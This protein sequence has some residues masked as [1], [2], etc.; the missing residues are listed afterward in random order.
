M[1]R[2]WGLAPMFLPEFDTENAQK[3]APTRG[4]MALLMTHDITVWPLWCNVN[5]ANRAMIA[6]DQYDVVAS[7]FI[8]YFGAKPPATSQSGNLIVSSYRKTA[9]D[10]LL[11]IANVSKERTQSR[12]C[13]GSDYPTANPVFVNWMKRTNIAAAAPRCFD[14]DVDVQDYAMVRVT[15]Q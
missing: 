10:H 8:P 15:G 1:G 14:V 13:L 3:V 11:V 9:S 5:E 7:E 6:L 12:I 4:L 2:Q